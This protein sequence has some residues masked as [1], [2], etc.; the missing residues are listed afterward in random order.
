MEKRIYPNPIESIATPEPFA[1]QSFTDAGEAVA[2]LKL[3]YDRNTEFLR[4]SFNQMAAS[5]PSGC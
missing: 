1:R 2:A 3:L 5:L 4:T